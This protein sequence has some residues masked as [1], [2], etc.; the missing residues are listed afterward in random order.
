MLSSH[1]EDGHRMYFGGSVVGKALTIG[2]GISPTP[3]LILYTTLF[4][5][6]AAYTTN[7]QYINGGG[8]K[9]DKLAWFKTSLNFEPPTFKTAARYLNSETKLQCCDYR[10]G[11]VWWSY[12]STH[13]WESSVSS[14]PP[15]KIACENALNHQYFSRGFFLT[16]IISKFN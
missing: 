15:P 2:T 4:A 14:D 1:A 12:R 11:K 16:F 5:W 13:R 6:K 10:P 7:K 9:S 3:P 8:S